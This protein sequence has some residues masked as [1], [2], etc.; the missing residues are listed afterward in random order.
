MITVRRFERALHEETSLGPARA[1]KSIGPA[2]TL[3]ST[4]TSGRPVA[5]AFS[6]G[7]TSDEK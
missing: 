2:Y 3:V 6:A 5:R 7:D 1:F 4:A